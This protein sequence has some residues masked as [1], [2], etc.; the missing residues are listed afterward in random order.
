MNNKQVRMKSAI[1]STTAALMITLAACSGNQQN[2]ITTVPPQQTTTTNSHSA[3][4]LASLLPAFTMED[5]NGR[6]I[7]LQSFTGKK[8]FVNLWASW[9]PPCRAEMPSIEK[10]SKSLDTSKVAFVMLSLDDD[11]TKAKKFM[12][13]QKL[14]LPVYYPAENLPTV[15]NVDAIPSTFIYNENGELLQQISG[16]NDYHSETFRQLLK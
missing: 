1:I 8:V 9:C 5:I 14:N 12:R 13:S 15:F 7:N 4:A 16:G 11:F 3:T 2:E 10:L 6:H